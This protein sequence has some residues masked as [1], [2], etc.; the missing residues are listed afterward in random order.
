MSN[1]QAV[2]NPISLDQKNIPQTAQT[3]QPNVF[4]DTLTQKLKVPSDLNAIFEEAAQK[5]NIPSSLLKA[6]GKTESGF[7]THAVSR[8]GAR[9]VMQLM[10]ATAKGLGVTDSFDP[11]QNIMGGAKYLS[12]MLNKYNGNTKLALAAYNAGSGNVDK[13][14][15]VP[16][17]KETQNY[18]VKVMQY[19][20]ADIESVPSSSA[21]LTG[22][23]ISAPAKTYVPSKTY[24]PASHDAGYNNILNSITGFDDFTTDDYLLFVELLKNSLQ[25]PTMGQIYNTPVS[26]LAAS[27]LFGDRFQKLF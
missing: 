2:A 22:G 7:N 10:P 11:R 5:Y 20:G 16:P 3:A 25:T 21:P 27:G 1:I 18:V 23:K 19:A 9:G 14:N 24:A 4:N 12:Q 6:V 17:F 13:Y 8:S 15:G 26:S